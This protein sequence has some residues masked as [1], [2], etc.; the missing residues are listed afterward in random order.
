MELPAVDFFGFK[1]SVFTKEELVQS[2]KENVNGKASKVYY[3]YSLG[4]LRFI[5]KYPSYHPITETFDVMVTDGRLFYLLAKLFGYKLKFDISI[6]R[7]TILTLEIA[8]E[9]NLKVMLIGGTIESN[10]KAAESLKAKYPGIQLCEGR[11]GYFMEDEKELVFTIIEQKAPNVLLLGFPT[12]AKQ[13]FAAE[14]KSRIKGCVII[15]C[16]GMIDILSGKEK[17]TP[18]WI[19]KIGLASFFRHFQHPKRFPEIFDIYYLTAKVFLTCFYYKFILRHKEIS[20]PLIL[21]GKNIHNNK[22]HN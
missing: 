7:M 10:G 9:L 21:K 19:K 5:K 4:V 14:I 6:P 13:I 17:L 3:G 16:G 12:P 8:N 15:P 1:V 11:D 2:I 18:L 22:V 20:V